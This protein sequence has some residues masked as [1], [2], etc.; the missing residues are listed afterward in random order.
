MQANK[1]KKTLRP[2]FAG[3]LDI[4]GG[5]FGAFIISP[6]LSCV[7]NFTGAPPGAFALSIAIFTAAIVCLAFIG[8]ICA[9]ARKRWRLALAGSIAVLILAWPIGIGAII[10]TKSSKEEFA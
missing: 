2:L 9:L 3:I 6:F 7:S 1:M 4:M 5:I 10:L 8:G